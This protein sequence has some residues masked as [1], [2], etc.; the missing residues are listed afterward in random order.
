MSRC[1]VKTTA[2]GVHL[3]VG[4]DIQMSCYFGHAYADG[5]MDEPTDSLWRTDNHGLTSWMKQKCVDLAD[6]YTA[7]VFSQIQ[8]D[9]DPG[10]VP[11]SGGGST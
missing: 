4:L 6:P 1:T 5:D 2:P 9:N 11:T 7:A 8:G 10:D 3:E